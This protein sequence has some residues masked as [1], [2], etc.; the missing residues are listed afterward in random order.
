MR[1]L[2]SLVK[3]GHV[4]MAF[5]DGGELDQ[6]A[7]IRL[8]HPELFGLEQA[9]LLGTNL[10]ESLGLNSNGHTVVPPKP[11][12]ALPA[13]K[14]AKRRKDM[15]ERER[16]A[17][18]RETSRKWYEKKKAGLVVSRSYPNRGKR[19]QRY[20]PLERVVAA[21]NEHPEGL[22]TRQLAAVVVGH[23]PSHL[24]QKQVE[25]RVTNALTKGNPP[26]RIAKVDGPNGLIR[27]HYPLSV[28]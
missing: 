22:T 15:S 12:Q 27:K 17:Y 2:V 19:D 3:D 25:N 7:L 8:P 10:I 20:I 13:A 14:P 11:A 6:F 26:F 1:Q 9:A 21:I 23:E 28:S 4:Q 24:E 16:K 18:D 5:L